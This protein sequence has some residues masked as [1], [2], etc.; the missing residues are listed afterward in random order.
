MLKKTTICFKV[1]QNESFL[2]LALS[3]QNTRKETDNSNEN[4]KKKV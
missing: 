3:I 4:H 1:L 2:L